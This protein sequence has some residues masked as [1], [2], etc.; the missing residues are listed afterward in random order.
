MSEEEKNVSELGKTKPYVQPALN[1][2]IEEPQVEEEYEEEDDDEYEYVTPHYT[3]NSILIV[4]FC[5]IIGAVITYF[6]A[7]E[8][9]QETIK[10]DYL[11]Q[12]YILTRDATALPSDIAEGKTA[13]VNGV[14]ITGTYVSVDTSIATATAADIIS[15]YT[16]YVNGVKIT[17]GITVFNTK[18]SFMPGRSP[19]TVAKK[20]TY[21]AE[22]IMIQG[23]AD[24]IAGN[25]KKGVTIFGIKGTYTGN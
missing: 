20:G 19:I 11:K 1:E 5:M 22:P 21:L 9:I 13:Y 18:T 12:G 15:G 16:A 23:D 6:L 10:A 17:G 14:K 4:V 3:R 25:I 24:L 2:E 7:A 8:S